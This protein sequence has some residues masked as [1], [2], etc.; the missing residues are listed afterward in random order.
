MNWHA[1]FEQVISPTLIVKVRKPKD[2][3][4]GHKPKPLKLTVPRG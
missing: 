1:W 2:L 3:E 4:K